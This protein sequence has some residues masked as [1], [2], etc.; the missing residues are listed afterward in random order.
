MPRLV[1]CVRQVVPA[2]IGAAAM[3]TLLA[4]CSS[5]A[6]LTFYNSRTAFNTAESGLPLEVFMPVIAP[7]LIPS[8]LSSMSNN[9]DFPAGNILPGIT[10]MDTNGSSLYTTGGAIGLFF[11]E[12]TLAIGFNPGTFAFGADVFGGSG[13]TPL[14]G[15]LT[16]D[17]FNGTTDLTPNSAF[18]STAAGQ[19]DF[20]GFSSPVQVTSVQFT[21]QPA[22]DALS[23][24]AYVGNIAFGSATVAPEPSTAAFS[25]L[26]AVLL[27]IGTM[28]KRARRN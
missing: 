1:S 6:T 22:N 4:A 24:S 2:V 21:F 14:A 23:G 28:V 8:P 7:G 26:A 5:A 25:A 13:S 17:V 3:L 20:I 11:L 27:G 18:F 12:D 16:M 10:L 9:S 15:T 19:S